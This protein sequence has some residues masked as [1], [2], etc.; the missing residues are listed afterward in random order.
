MGDDLV[1]C[2][3]SG[4]VSQRSLAACCIVALAMSALVATGTASSAVAT[5]GGPVTVSN[6]AELTAAVANGGVINIQPGAYDVTSELKIERASTELRAV[7]PGSVTIRYVGTAG[8][9]IMV[10]AKNVVI[11]GVIV[12]GGNNPW[13]DGGGGIE[14]EDD[15]SLTLSRSTITGN[16][17]D[18]GGGILNEGTIAVVDSTISNNTASIKG[19][20]LLNEGTATVTNSTIEGNTSFWG[21]GIASFSTINLNHTTIVRNVTTTSSTSYGALQR[22][23]GTFNV[24]YS[25]VGDNLRTNG[26]A[27]RNCAGTVRLLD[28]NLLTSTAGCTTSGTE[29]VK[30]LLVGATANN[31]G[32]TPTAALLDGSPAID[33]VNVSA[34]KCASGVTSDQRG[35]A[36]PFG[37]KCDLGAFEKAALELADP[38]LSVDTSNYGGL[39]AGT[40]EVGAT[41]VPTNL[42]AGEFVSDAATNEDGTLD[43]ARL[44]SIRLRSIRL[45]SI[46][47]QDIRLRSIDT[48]TPSTPEAAR[49][50]SIEVKANRLRSIALESIRLRSI[51]LDSTRLRSIDAA[52]AR[53]RSIRLRSI[54]LSE[55]PLTEV[56]GGWEAQLAL[57]EFADVPLQ[58]LTLAEV[59]RLV[60]DNFTLESIDLSST[61]LRSIRL[62]SILLEGTRLRSIPLSDDLIAP[63]PENDLAW[64]AAL[65]S[66]SECTDRRSSA[67]STDLELWEA[68]LAGAD[69]DQPTVLDVP[70]SGLTSARLRS[71]DPSATDI[72][73]ARLRSIRLRSIFLENTALSAIRLRSIRLRSIPAD[74]NG[75]AIT[76][77][78]I[79]DCSKNA[80]ACTDTDANTLTLRDVAI[81]CLP[82]GATPAD[83]AA[84]LLRDDA[85]FGQ[86]IDLLGV[87][88]AGV[89]L[90]EGLTL[91]DILLAFSAPEDIPWESVDLQASPLQ[92]IATPPQPTFDYVVD[93]QISQGPATI[94]VDMRLPQGFALAGGVE[95]KAATFCPAAAG[96]CD[97][98]IAPSA[99][100]TTFVIP[101]AAS[102]SYKLRVPVRAGSIV[103]GA[104]QFQASSTVTATGTN[105]ASTKDSN[106]VGVNVVQA[107]TTAPS[108][109]NLRDGQLELGYI[110]GSG[111]LDVYSFVAPSGSTGASARILLSNIPADVDYDLA[112]Y[113]PRAVSLRGAPLPDRPAISDDRFDLDPGDDVLPTDVVDDIALDITEIAPTVGLI[114]PPE[115]NGYALRD[116]SSR[117][118][119]TDEEVTLPALVSGK[120]YV[121]V[122]S[123]YFGDVSPEPYGLRVRLDRRT[124]IPACATS[125]YPGTTTAPAV[126][127]GL[128]ITAGTNTLYVTN[129]A[130]LDREAGVNGTTNGSAE[131]LTAIAATDGVNGVDAGLLLLD[132]LTEWNQYN[133]GGCDPDIRNVLAK[134]IGNAIDGAN[135]VAGAN[136]NIE[137]IV[138]VGG[139]G[140]VPMAAVPDLAE[141]SNE[142]TFALS[143]LDSS[144]AG[145]PIAG[146]LAS[147]FFLSDDPYATDA[148]I[149]I[150][151][152]DHELYVPDRNVGRV[153][154]TADEIVAQLENFVTYGGKVDPRTFDAAVTGYDFLN[155][156]AEAVIA[157]LGAEFEV[158]SLLGDEWDRAGYLDLFGNGTDYSVFSP[159]AHY[160]FEALLPALPDAEGVYD[161]ND[162]VDTSDFVAGSPT[163]AR[164]PLR[165]LGFTVGCHAGLNVSDVQVGP[166]LDWAQLYSQ[167]QTQ[168][169]AHTTYGYGDTEIVAYSERLATLFA[170]NVAAM[171][172]VEV[173]APTS[174]GA[175]V[176]DAKQRYLA[177][178]LV[179]SPYDEKILQSWTYYGLPMYSIGE[180]PPPATETTL[181]APV[182]ETP[183]VDGDRRR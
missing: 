60:P 98:P 75:P 174:L 89:S 157:E 102:G 146:A 19:G 170:G 109:P 181:D 8:R 16:S 78:S 17:D 114:L 14:V 76:L 101:S 9:P 163:G 27:A 3:T 33:V 81:T 20:G 106:A 95:S 37:A 69:V 151:G 177:S 44:R 152:G 67:Q 63:S 12:T 49:L 126:P 35:T 154:E 87:E 179:I 30:P 94:T 2:R 121:V 168:W 150:L 134:A 66:E 21:S 144:D 137:N 28:R 122:V 135:G 52:S 47:L 15:A 23:S 123:G 29:I 50:R 45:R 182:E 32:P 71:I 64:C 62:R 108:A 128:E 40:V 92:N 59:A 183:I 143:V 100:T 99:D 56:P 142:S 130:R 77:E 111:E 65:I 167:N 165:A 104:A 85:D 161:E 91:G 140:V 34:G 131:V 36:R 110:G 145:T 48:S 105:G 119:N 80:V 116:I 96:P 138:F 53:L 26:S 22:F 31:G 178:T 115:S 88:V 162:L 160:D 158:D 124:A 113:G 133:A 73:D 129:A 42:I 54:P 103:G 39:P 120:T 180:P 10:D 148:G 117:R 51:D 41:S 176:R 127:A 112:V 173:D 139:D 171:A 159:N 58:S 86:L 147:G 141:Y 83:N 68:Q 70:L 46:E 24:R 74:T 72:E 118:S 5:T 175:A 6:T 90:L 25:I 125:T 79:I 18:R 7:T 153:V 132:G 172:G 4:R 11:D 43:S 169:V 107:G 155:D 38:V 164:V 156:G 1:R 84:C 136:G 166:T 149:S 82:E 93:V 97:N 55:I 57:T 13:D 61:R